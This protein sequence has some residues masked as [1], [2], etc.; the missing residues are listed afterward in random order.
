MT[1]QQTSE[2]HLLDLILLIAL[3]HSIPI[4][5]SIYNIEMVGAYFRAFRTM[6]L[7]TWRD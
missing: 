6:Y 5:D 1:I 2:P 7:I 4:F 3:A